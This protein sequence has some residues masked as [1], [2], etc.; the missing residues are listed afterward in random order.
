MSPVRDPEWQLHIPQSRYTINVL[1]P[2]LHFNL[3]AR[4]GSQEALTA[5]LS[6]FAPQNKG[7]AQTVS[8]RS[9]LSPCKTYIVTESEA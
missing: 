7:T 8:Q 5:G 4:L 1:A 9:R 6:L 2:L 3:G